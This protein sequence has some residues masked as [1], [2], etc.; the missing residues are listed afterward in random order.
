MD[1]HSH[2]KWAMKP[3]SDLQEDDTDLAVADPLADKTLDLWNS[4]A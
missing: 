3:A 4:I 2:V 1:G